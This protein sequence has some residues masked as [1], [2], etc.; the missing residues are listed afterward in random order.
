MYYAHEKECVN[1]Y[2]EGYAPIETW[3]NRRCWEFEQ[4]DENSTG[5]GQMKAKKVAKQTSAS[6]D[7]EGESPNYLKVESF[8]HVPR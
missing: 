5:K 1:L 7:T 8:L 6:R 4:Y 2:G 3:G